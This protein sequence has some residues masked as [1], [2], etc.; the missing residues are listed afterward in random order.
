MQ[1]D[2]RAFWS[3][4]QA[5]I[6]VAVASSAPDKLLGV[7]DGF[8]RCFHDGLGR[9][10]PIAVVPHQDGNERLGLPMS[11]EETIR[12][13]RRRATELREELGATY[14]F[15]VGSEGG[16][17][18]LELEG[19]M[20]YFVSSWTV[21]VGLAGEAWGASGSVEIPQ[22]LIQGLDDHQIPFAIPGTRRKGGMTSSITG[23]LETRRSA[24][25]VS[26][27]N[28]LSTVLYGILESH[29]LRRS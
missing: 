15:Y 22:R 14:H 11:D 9:P 29:P 18:S 25:S 7:R 24:V 5:G 8:L 20:H 1:R 12:L 16:L 3:R 26:T 19:K 13:A 17:H 2:L 23:G 28:A 21:I 6:E 4:F 27:F 10:I